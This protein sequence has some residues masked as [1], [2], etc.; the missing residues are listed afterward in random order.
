MADGA[1]QFF[2]LVGPGGAGN[3]PLCENPAW[4]GDPVSLIEVRGPTPF[5]LHHNGNISGSDCI[6]PIPWAEVPIGLVA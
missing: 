4:G 6:R 2:V 1:A 3:H 5:P